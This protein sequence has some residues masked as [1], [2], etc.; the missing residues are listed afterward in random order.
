MSGVAVVEAAW[1]DGA[2]VGAEALSERV[3]AAAG[4]GELSEAGVG[5]AAGVAVEVEATEAVAVA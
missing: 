1:A 5:A 4:A 2:A 3:G